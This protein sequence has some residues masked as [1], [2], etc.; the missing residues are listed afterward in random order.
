MNSDK[1]NS[2]SMIKP[3]GRGS[4]FMQWNLLNS[5]PPRL[6]PAADMNQ[7]SQSSPGELGTRA[8][9]RSYSGDSSSLSNSDGTSSPIN[10]QMRGLKING[11]GC[12]SADHQSDN[13]AFIARLKQ[14]KEKLELSISGGISQD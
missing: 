9:N 8:D 14:A 6:A 10:R 3:G 7:L 11:I 5:M 13:S 2:S 4:A 12:H 1:L